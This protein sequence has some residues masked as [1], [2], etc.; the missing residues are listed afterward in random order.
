MRSFLIR[1]EPRKEESLFSFLFR[2]AIA[3]HNKHLA[4]IFKE[5]AALIYADNCNY[6]D[7]R[8]VWVPYFSN[9]MKVNGFDINEFVL[10][11][12]NTVLNSTVTK[13][14][15]QIY[16]TQ[17]TKYCPECLKEDHF[18]RLF[19]DVR[20][21]THCIKHNRM[22]VDCCPKCMNK[23]RASR[24]MQDE[25]RCGFQFSNNIVKYEQN[26]EILDIQKIIQGLLLENTLDNYGLEL[27]KDFFTAKEYFNIFNNFYF[28]IDYLPGFKHVPLIKKITNRLLKDIESTVPFVMHAHRLVKDT[29]G[30]L[31]NV[32]RAIDDL[33]YTNPTLYRRKQRYLKNIFNSK[34]GW[35]HYQKYSEYLNQK[36]NEYINERTL[37]PPLPIEKK[38]LTVGEAIKYLKT[39]HTTIMR[40]KK[41]ELI[42][43]IT[44][45][46]NGR[47]VTLFEKASLDK[48][49]KMKKESLGQGAICQ[50][51]GV[52]FYTFKELVKRKLLT[53][54]HGPLI[55]GYNQ[56][57][58]Y[59]THLQLFI[60][61]LTKHTETIS[62]ISQ[63]WV[64]FK[65]GF[66]NLRY[67]MKWTIADLVE[68][69]MDGRIYSAAAGNIEKLNDLL[70]NRN[71]IQK[72][73]A[74]NKR[75]KLESKGYSVKK[76]ARALCCST[77]KIEKMIVEGKLI[78]NHIEIGENG[79]MTRYINEE[80]I[81]NSIALKESRDT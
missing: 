12:Y 29:E 80:Q 28:I 60:E 72:I 19:W 33:K 5:H 2:F 25:C 36:T 56:W 21:V 34:M 69:V 41:F 78:V 42:N 63:E 39:E 75:E 53:G 58:F 67:D 49:L 31:T 24:L 54:L 4:S 16:N 64:P 50:K 9:V 55:D 40:L 77:M 52:S 23:I 15:K 47:G 32:L 65:I 59:E 7:P 20:F 26:E 14:Y 13:N 43:T 38:Y 48:Y 61:N 81:A 66:L 17:R 51:L 22:L 68:F 44:S 70:L 71:Q 62:N 8:S 73:V 3:N 74:S 10:N 76:A 11:K 79:V 6:T 18:I 45:D 27:Q 35:A 37:L 57:Y 1:I 30:D 46:V